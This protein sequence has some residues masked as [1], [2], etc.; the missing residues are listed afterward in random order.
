MSAVRTGMPQP[1]FGWRQGRLGATRHELP[2]EVDWVKKG[3]QRRHT[4]TLTVGDSGAAVE[5]RRARR[6]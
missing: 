3:K 2:D 1:G 4:T 6:A 5:A